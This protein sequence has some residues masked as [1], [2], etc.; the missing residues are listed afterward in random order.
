MLHHIINNVAGAL[1][2]SSIKHKTQIK[3]HTRG[4]KVEQYYSGGNERENSVVLRR[5]QKTDNDGE[6]L[7][8]DGRVFQAVAAA[9]GNAR[10][11]SVDRRVAGTR[12][13]SASAERRHRRASLSATR[14][15]ELA[16]YAGAVPWRQRNAR[17]H[18]RNWILSLIFSQ[19]RSRRYGVTWS[20]FCPANT[21]YWTSSVNL[22]FSLS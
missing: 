21:R 13:V 18:N 17:T 3:T 12:S 9:T 19:W 4:I 1:Y 22:A 6:C 7:T 5:L 16:R 11:P 8:A 10:S 20:Y 2:N 15:R 14:W